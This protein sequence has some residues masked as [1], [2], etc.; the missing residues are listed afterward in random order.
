MI[1]TV[2]VLMT[3]IWAV[4]PVKLPRVLSTPVSVP[5]F[6]GMSEEAARAFVAAHPGT[7]QLV[8]R[9]QWPAIPWEAVDV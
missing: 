8:T 1:E 2:N 3:R 5:N 7:H 4:Q 9:M 6:H